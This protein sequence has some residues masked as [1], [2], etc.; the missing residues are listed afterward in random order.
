MSEIAS[1]NFGSLL[2]NLLLHT[3]SDVCNHADLAN[4]L[5]LLAFSYFDGRIMMNEYRLNAIRS[6]PVMHEHFLDGDALH[7]VL[8]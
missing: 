1:G 5:L 6:N 8:V 2:F 7:W 3:D 4:R